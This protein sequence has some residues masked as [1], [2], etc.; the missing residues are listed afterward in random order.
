MKLDILAAIDIG[1]NAVRL[2]IDYVEAEGE[3]YDLKKAAYLRVPIRLGEDVF[4]SYKVSDAKAERLTETMVGFQHLMRAYGVS[5]FRACATSAMRDAVNGMRLTAAIREKT[6]IDIEIISGQE[7][8]D[9]VYAAGFQKGFA[10]DADAT[11]YIDVGGGST[12]LV[13]YKEHQLYLHDS[14]QVGTVR[15]LSKAAGKN[16]AAWEVEK[17]RFA[18]SFKDIYARYAP[19]RVV[20]SGGNINKTYKMLGKKNGDP[21]RPEEI[22]EL[23]DK[24]EPLSIPERMH[25]FG[26][27]DYRA[28]VIVPALQIFL[29]VCRECPSI[30]NIYVPKIGLADGLIHDMCK[31]R[32]AAGTYKQE[33]PHGC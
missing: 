27:N 13:L 28:D 19:V 1:S 22:K 25:R 7:E 6:G 29:S 10:G 24:L 26:L 31:K 20:A 14:F 11:L 8:A 2:L 16:E 4:I 15:M 3:A 9:L 33:D 5:E 23:L 21:L 17:E 32:F 18:L 30:R 12:E